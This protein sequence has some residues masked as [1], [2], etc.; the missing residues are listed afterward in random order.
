MIRKTLTITLDT[1][2]AVRF[3][4]TAKENGVPQNYLIEEFMRL[5]LEDK[6]EVVIKNGRNSIEIKD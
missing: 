5:Y 2:I 6:I 1:D 3:K 4:E